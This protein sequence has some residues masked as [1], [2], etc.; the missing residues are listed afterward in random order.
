L[1]I[2][3][4]ISVIASRASFLGV[5]LANKYFFRSALSFESTVK[6]ILIKFAGIASFSL[7]ISK[8]VTTSNVLLSE[9]A[10]LIGRY[11]N[12]QLNPKNPPSFHRSAPDISS[13]ALRVGIN[14]GGHFCLSL[15]T[16]IE[17]I[18]SSSAIYVT[19]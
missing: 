10:R 7:I 17:T 4:I 16:Q 6:S 1:S 15:I 13:N 8:S 3:T 14:A 5:N 18:G 9:M 2:I 11:R 19:L 12:D